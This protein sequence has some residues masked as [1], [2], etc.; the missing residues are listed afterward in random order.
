MTTTVAVS[1]PTAISARKLL[2]AGAIVGLVVF[3]AGWIVAE[4]I[5]G[6]GYSVARHDISDLGALTAHY[7]TLIRATDAVGGLLVIAF[8]LGALVPA[9]A[10][11]GRRVAI[12]AVL[13]AASL[14]AFDTFSDT[15]FRLDC[16]A[17]DAACPASAATTSWHGKAHIVAF[18]IAALATAIAPFLLARRMQLLDAWRDLARPTRLFSF[19]F[20][21]LIV[22]SGA[23]TNSS[24][25]GWAQRITIFYV[26]GATAALAWRTAR[27]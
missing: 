25:G 23:T 9:L 18:V 26:C 10:V 20:I 12:G 5:E 19:G 8:A 1:T 13:V 27:T 7:P 21:A 22:V 24:V 11:P 2:S 14:P 4:A 6:H 3:C 17:A 16:R 15:F